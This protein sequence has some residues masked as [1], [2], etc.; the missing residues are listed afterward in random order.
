MIAEL[1]SKALAAE[2][3]GELETAAKL[4]A[5]CSFR[6]LAESNY[7]DCP[8]MRRG[9]THMLESI[10]SDVR[11]SNFQRAQVH[12]RMTE[13]VFY[14]LLETSSERTIQG[15]ASEWLGD[16]Y[17]MLEDDAAFEHYE[18]A[19]EIFQEISLQNRL[20]WGAEPEFDN[21]YGAL[22]EFLSNYGIEYPNEYTIEFEQRVRTKIEALQTEFNS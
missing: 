2:Q 8:Q 22:K 5:F 16:A 6:G 20:F 17:F 19:L 13:P 9:L 1:T 12:L 3:D 11:T 7:R 4:Y 10:S 15:L 21:A 14:L 18:Q